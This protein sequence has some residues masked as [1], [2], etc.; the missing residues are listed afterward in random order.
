[1]HGHTYIKNNKNTSYTLG[2][3][4]PDKPSGRLTSTFP[5]VTFR[6]AKTNDFALTLTMTTPFPEY[7]AVL[8]GNRPPTFQTNNVPSSSRVWRFDFPEF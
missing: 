3:S 2:M 8:L 4:R 6:P 1:M 5:A 7:E